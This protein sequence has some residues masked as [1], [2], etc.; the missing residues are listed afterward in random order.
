MFVKIMDSPK[1]KIS[2][3]ACDCTEFKPDSSLSISIYGIY[4]ICF[5]NIHI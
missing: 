5:I 3:H 1:G 4:I 2:I